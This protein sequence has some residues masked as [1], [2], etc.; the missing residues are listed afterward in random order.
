MRILAIPGSLRRQSCNR[1]LLLELQARY[2]A[3]P[4]VVWDDLKAIPP[5]DEDDEI[6]PPAAVTA[7]RAA[8]AAADAL[9][10]ATPEYNASLPGQLKNALDWLS[11]PIA[12]TPLR[13]KPAAVVGT[14]SGM[15]GGVWAQ[16]E[17]RKVLSTIGAR[18]LERS[19]T[20]PYVAGPFGPDV[21]DA[22]GE[23]LDELAEAASAGCHR[24]SVSATP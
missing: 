23:L 15:F 22:I 9:L 5:F 1:R 11:R 16:A 18:V 24:M 12:A 13:H 6:A 19:V 17:L 3:G 21:H 8:T 20:V 4:M 10:F 2:D 14:S 7:L